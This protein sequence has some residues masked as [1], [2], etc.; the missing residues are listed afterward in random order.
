MGD[1][2]GEAAWSPNHWIPGCSMLGH[3]LPPH[4]SPTTLPCR[5]WSDRNFPRAL[6]KGSGNLMKEVWYP[7]TK[8]GAWKHTGYHRTDARIMDWGQKS[9]SPI[10]KCTAGHLSGEIRPATLTPRV[11]MSLNCGAALWYLHVGL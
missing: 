10:P 1:W 3:H 8:F 7:L 6:S 4:T 11:V 9:W 2:A 5:L